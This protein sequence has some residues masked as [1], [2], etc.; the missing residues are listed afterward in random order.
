MAGGGGAGLDAARKL[1]PEATVDEIRASGLR[2]RGGGGFPTGAK[3]SGVRGAKGTHR[4]VVGNA[5]EGEPGTFKDRALMRRN[6]YQLVEGVAIAAF[7]VGATE[8]F[9]GLKASFTPEIAALERALREMGEAG[10]AGDVPIRLVPGELAVPMV[11]NHD[12]PRARMWGTLER[13]SALLTR[14]GFDSSTWRCPGRALTGVQPIWG[15]VE[16]RPW[17]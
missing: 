6:P 2:G 10:L 15:A 14:V 11:W 8:A 5:A 16:N 3:W 9:I 4:Y 17:R 7:A 1:G 13:V 12:G